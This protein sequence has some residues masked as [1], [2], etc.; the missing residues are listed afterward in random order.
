MLISKRKEMSFNTFTLNTLCQLQ[1]QKAAKYGEIN[2]KVK[3][4]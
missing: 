3:L 4:L 2:L 1:L